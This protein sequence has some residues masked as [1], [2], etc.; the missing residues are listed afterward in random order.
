MPCFTLYYFNLFNGINARGTDSM[1][2]LT[3]GGGLSCGK[4]PSSFGSS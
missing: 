3:L 2:Y 1:Y 4:K